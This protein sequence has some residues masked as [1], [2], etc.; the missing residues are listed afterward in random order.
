MTDHICNEPWGFNRSATLDAAKS[1]FIMWLSPPFYSQTF[2]ISSILFS[3]V[4]HLFLPIYRTMRLL[5][6]SQC[7]TH[8]HFGCYTK[9][10]RETSKPDQ[11]SQFNCIVCHVQSIYYH[12]LFEHGTLSKRQPKTA[13]KIQKVHH[14]YTLE[15]MKIERNFFSKQIICYTRVIIFFPE[16]VY[17]AFRSTLEHIVLW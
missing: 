11:I 9:W 13:K 14:H 6:K 1:C 5:I 4:L 17:R 8:T 15:P 16:K 10:K 7:T 12:E 3:S 2:S